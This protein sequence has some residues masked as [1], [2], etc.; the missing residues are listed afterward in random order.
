MTDHVDRMRAYYEDQIVRLMAAARTDALTGL[1][2]YRAFMGHCVNLDGM[3]VP[4]SVVLLDMTNLKRANAVLGHFGAD[5]LLQRVGSAIR[6]GGWDAVYR[7]GGDE[8]A[9]VLPRSCRTGALLVRERI[10]QAVGTFTLSDGTQVR[11]IG[12]VA[13]VQPGVDLNDELNRADHELERRKAEWK[14]T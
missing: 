5:T 7:Y 8:F 10:E 2:N 4:F 1:G 3:G 14:A 13:Y 9:V 6:G 12:A 11:A